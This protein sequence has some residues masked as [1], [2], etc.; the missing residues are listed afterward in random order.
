MDK[1]GALPGA[2]VD[3]VAL[4]A[5]EGGVDADADAGADANGAPAGPDGLGAGALPA[6]GAAA[7][8]AW[9]GLTQAL[10]STSALSK[11]GTKK[12]RQVMA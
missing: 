8:P 3:D 7:G 4:G 5:V 9:G 6:S 1:N 10:S 2:P 11:A 12:G